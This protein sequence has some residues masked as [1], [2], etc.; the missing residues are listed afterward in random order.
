MEEAVR[1]NATQPLGVEADRGSLQR[2]ERALELLLTHR[3]NPAAQVERI[4]SED[5]HCVFAHCLRAALIVC[6]DRVADR[7]AV[8]ESL[9]AIEA[10][11]PDMQ[12]PARRH[13]AAADA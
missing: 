2:C 11:C 6:G 7:S 9:A 5:P 1:F 10:S 13:A 12:D 8:A 3:G 4:L